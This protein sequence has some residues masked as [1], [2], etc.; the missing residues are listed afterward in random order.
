MLTTKRAI[1][2]PIV[3][4]AQ[5]ARACGIHLILSTQRPS[6]DV[7]TGLIKANA[8]TRLSYKTVTGTDSRVILDQVGAQR[9]LG[10]GDSY[11]RDAG[12]FGLE[13]IQ[14]SYASNHDIESMC[15]A[16]T[17]MYSKAETIIKETEY[18]PDNWFDRMV[19]TV[20]KFLYRE[21]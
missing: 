7:L 9:L 11:Y 14:S 18:K 13:R 16:V 5:K 15:K 6:V 4:L 8:P 3:R 20:L 17:S 12:S 2:S 21:A 1:E 10:K 19:Y